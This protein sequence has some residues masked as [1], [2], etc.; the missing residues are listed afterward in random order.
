MEDAMAADIASRRA[1]ASLVAAACVD[2]K[3]ADPE[4]GLLAR[5]ARELQLS[6][7]ELEDFLQQGLQGRLTVAVPPTPL[8]KQALLEDLIRVACADGRVEQPER[9]LLMRYG[10]MLGIDPQDLGQRVRDGLNRSRNV[11]REPQPQPQ[12]RAPQPPP[13]R[14]EPSRVDHPEPIRYVDEKQVMPEPASHDRPQ[15]EAMSSRE[16]LLAVAPGPI[17]IGS[18]AAHATDGLSPVTQELVKNSIRFDG[19]DEAVE[20]VLRTCGISDRAEAQRLVD[21]IIADDPNCKPG[22]LKSKHGR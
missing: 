17:R 9:A 5:K 16:N 22:S 3:I 6:T 21:K 14:K 20:Y 19:R 18:M 4:R 7:A 11:T 2:G 1:F 8:G 12:A 10:G 13:K 15:P